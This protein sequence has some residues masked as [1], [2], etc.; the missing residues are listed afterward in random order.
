VSRSVPRRRSVSK[1]VR[2]SSNLASS[3]R[4]RTSSK[5]LATSLGCSETSITA[6]RVAFLSHPLVRNAGK[7]H[8][9]SFH[10]AT[11]SF[12]NS[13]NTC[14]KCCHK[15]LTRRKRAKQGREDVPLQRWVQMHLLLAKTLPCQTLN[16]TLATDYLAA[17][18]Q[19]VCST[20]RRRLLRQRCLLPCV[21]F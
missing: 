11:A 4:G 2:T 10:S 16:N 7:R 19:C 5:A 8:L 6:S 15:N 12:G 3:R 20:V 9:K 13:L 17:L 1:C 14:R 21:H 18:S